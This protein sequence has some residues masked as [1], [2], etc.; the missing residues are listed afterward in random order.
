MTR[1]GYFSAKSGN[2]DEVN[3]AHLSH[4]WDYLRQAIMC[5]ADTTLE[6]LGAPP[7][8]IGSTGWGYEHQCRDY[9][10]VFAYAT[11]HRLTD[12]KVIHS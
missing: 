2:L 8:D 4:C 11:A 1:T 7:D 12:K 6:W 9:T 3:M 5:H 10:A